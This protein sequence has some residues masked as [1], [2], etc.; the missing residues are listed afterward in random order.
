MPLNAGVEVEGLR[1]FLRGLKKLDP[2]LDKAIKT[3][4][5]GVAEEVASDARQL[6]PSKSGRARG[7]IRSGADA[8]GPYLAGGK[9]SVP[10]FGWLD[11]GARTPVAGNP[12][13]Y[14]PWFRSGAGPKDGRFIYPAI[15]RNKQTIQEGG[16]QA[17]ANALDASGL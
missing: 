14:G 6:A 1:E 12:R 17:L 10:Y 7:S 2:E 11:F 5:K 9:K 4:L 8:R 15:R 16:E 13:S 3:E